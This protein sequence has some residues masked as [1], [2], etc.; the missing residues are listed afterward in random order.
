ML[1]DDD[2][3]EAAKGIPG[4]ML[5]DIAFRGAK[6]VHA[7]L[8]LARSLAVGNAVEHKVSAWI[9]IVINPPEHRDEVRRLD[10]VVYGVEVRRD[11]IHAMGQPE[12]ADVLA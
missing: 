2:K 6:P 5:S 1:S 9:E 11:E 4:Y 7:Q 3:D 8:R 12:L 10:D